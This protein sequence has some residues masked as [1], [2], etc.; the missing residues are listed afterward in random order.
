MASEESDDHQLEIPALGRN[1]EIGI[2]YDARRDEI[3]SGK[4]F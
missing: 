1:F 4:F 2:L 3:K